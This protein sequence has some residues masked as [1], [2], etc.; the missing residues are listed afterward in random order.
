MLTFAN[1]NY[2]KT[3]LMNILQPILLCAALALS[4]SAAAAGNGLAG[5]WPVEDPSNAMTLDGMW[6]VKVVRGITA[7]TAVPPRDDTW[8]TIGV[9]GCWEAAGLCEP[10]YNMPDSLTGYYRTTFDIPA[11]W[12]K[13]RI[14]LR[15]D[16]VLRAFDLWINGQYAGRWENAYNARQFDI[17]PFLRKSGRQ[18]LAMRVYS[19]YRGFEFDCYDDWAPMGIHR[20]VWLFAFPRTHI[21]DIDV[22]TTIDGTVRVRTAIAN[23]T[24]HT[25]T[26]C[27]LADA[28]GRTV[29]TGDLMH[30]AKPHLWTAETPYLY[31]LTVRLL[32]R[33]RLLQTHTQNV[34]IREVEISGKELLI[35]RRPVK[36]R[37][38]T[39]HATDPKTVKVVGEELNLR[40]M[41]LMKEASINYIRTSHYIREPRFYELA[42]SLGFYI[43]TE[44]SIGSRGRELLSEP[45]MQDQMRTRVSS[46]IARYKGHPSIIAWTIG[47]ENP[48][49]DS[50]QALAP[51]AKSLDRTRPV[52]FP[53]TEATFLGY[54]FDKFPK[55]AD[56]YAPHYP[57]TEHIADYFTRA[58]RPVVFT[59]YSHS[60]GIAFEDHDRQWDIIERTPCL[61]GGSVWE[62]A[63]Q[64]MP[65]RSAKKF[66]PWRTDG[67]GR[68]QKVYTSEHG[69]FEMNGNFG[70]DGLLY[71]DRT[72]LPGYYELQRNYAR[73]FAD[74][75]C[76]D[77]LTIVNRFDFIG[78]KDNVT[79]RWA[80]TDGT[81]TICR[82]AFSPDIAPRGQ[83]RYVLPLAEARSLSLLELAISDNAGNTFLRQSFVVRPWAA[84]NAGKGSRDTAANDGPAAKAGSA[85]TIAA[86]IPDAADFLIRAGRKVSM[87]ERLTQRGKF[88]RRYLRHQGDRLVRTDI[89]QRQAGGGTHFDYALTPDSAGV[90]YG[91]LGLAW[92]LPSGCHSVQWLGRGP[93]P[94]YP[95]RRRA[96][97]YGVWGLHKDDIYFEGNRTA[98]EAVWIADTDDGST[99][100]QGCRPDGGGLLIV[101]DSAANVGIEQTDRGIVIT[102]NA[103]V[104]GTGSKFWKTHYNVEAGRTYK[105]GFTIYRLP[106]TPDIFR[107]DVPVPLHPFLTQYDTYLLRYD[108]IVE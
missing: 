11:R 61:A 39:L 72:P 77:T 41:R 92:L 67:S 59:E 37:G 107:R 36:L 16:G 54:G 86:H 40:D 106:A 74:T 48:F 64:G 99:G 100:K 6:A 88:L 104:S 68:D 1:P 30:I 20:S 95:G 83:G 90:F 26:E 70:T 45:D 32:D 75:L 98:V 3:I 7:D 87:A 50:L 103:A 102:M 56:I 66:S 84:G 69:G 55:V 108:D 9:P 53:Q 80:Q 13:Q 51:Y 4:Q 8:T 22:R 101:P 19:R 12:A 15:L 46:T 82:G 96:G 65:F 47:N 23:P 76:G 35:N 78:L 43:I 31:K 81:D 63:D 21:A 25:T 71:A 58:D 17:T 49:P 44:A 29:A 62:W 33:G 60:L 24:R 28:A 10:R 57:T 38:V 93:Y 5:I 27:T 89:R 42:D 79:F 97:R 91:E 105:G 34:G 73:A 2:T 85:G 14:G 52:C 94:T 18:E